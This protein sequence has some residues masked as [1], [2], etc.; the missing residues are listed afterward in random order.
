MP[1]KISQEILSSFYADDTCY[2]ASDSQHKSRKN[3]VSGYLQPILNDLEQFCNKW[4]IGLNPDKTFCMNFYL[5]SLDNN[6]PRLWL[7]G[8]LLEYKKEYKFLGF[9]FNQ[10]LSHKAHIQDVINRCNKRLNL[11]KAIKGKSWGASP[12]TIIYTYKVYIRP[13]LEYGSI[14]FAHSDENF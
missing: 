2:A 5:N 1:T 11:L 8:N 14:L 12:S 3:F 10:N 9:T 7:M 4:Y 6:T 13:I